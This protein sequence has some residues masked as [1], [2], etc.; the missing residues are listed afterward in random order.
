EFGASVAKGE[1]R[2]RFKRDARIDVAQL[3][4]AAPDLAPRVTAEKNEVTVALTMPTGSKLHVHH[5]DNDVVVDLP[6]VKPVAIA[7][8]RPAADKATPA[9]PVTEAAAEKP[10]TDKAVGEK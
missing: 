6:P 9:K 4:A 7:A 8:A 5:K 1:A 2:I 10:A 3:A